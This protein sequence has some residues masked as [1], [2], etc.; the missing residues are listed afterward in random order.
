MQPIT[1]QEKTYN[2]S[3]KAQKCIL[4]VLFFK[5]HFFVLQDSRDGNSEEKVA[6]LSTALKITPFP[7][8]EKKR[9]CSGKYVFKLGLFVILNLYVSM[10]ICW[11]PL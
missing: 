6:V 5:M 2:F 3:L 4:Q 7:Q 1:K 10:Q 8:F 9:P 11:I